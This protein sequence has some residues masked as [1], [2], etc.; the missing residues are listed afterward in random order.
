MAG[1]IEIIR[2]CRRCDGTGLV[3]HQTGGNPNGTCDRCG[4]S[5]ETSWDS[6]DLSDL[7]DKVQDVLNKC[8]DILEKLN[9]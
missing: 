7:E 6:F 1:E 9:E 3:S 2:R 4:G 8:N 5:G